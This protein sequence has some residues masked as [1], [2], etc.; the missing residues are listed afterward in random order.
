VIEA[1]GLVVA[2]GLVDLHVHLRQPGQQWKETIATGSRAAAAGG[3]T[4][5]V[6]EP[7]T[8][9]PLDTPE[10]LEGLARI[11]ARDALMRVH[12]KA[13]ITERERGERVV[14]VDGVKLA[15]AVALSDDGEPVLDAAVMARALDEARRHEMVITPH[16]EESPASREVAPAPVPYT[17]E[18]ELVSRDVVLVARHGG[19][20]HF[21]HISMGESARFIGEAKR[22]GHA[23]TAEATPHHLALSRDDA[24]PDDTSFKMNPPLRSR[25]DVEAV[26]RALAHGVIDSIATDHA[27]HA[28]EEKALPYDEAPFGVIG[29]ETALGVVITELV[30]KGAISLGQAIERMSTN[31]ARILGL[32][33][34]TLAP[35]GPADIVA[36]DPERSWVVEPKLFH[37]KGRNCPF[38]GRTLRGRAVFT[39][40]GGS[41]VLREGEVQE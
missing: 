4:T 17:R 20:V 6:C 15:G 31:P 38:A 12:F 29:L 39:V 10:M 13:C 1:A 27:P 37:S 35:G 40:V 36:F 5:V 33:G 32:R 19:R 30:D 8:P 24:S 16:C 28:P 9:P 25:E 11:A 23:I 21:S 22:N 41:V 26:R 2:P 18:P 34:G 7:N 14:K 3:F